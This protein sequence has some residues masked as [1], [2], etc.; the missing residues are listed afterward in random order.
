MRGSPHALHALLAGEEG[1]AVGSRAE[2]VCSCDDRCLL[3]RWGVAFA[4]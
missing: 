1:E 3:P 4:P 2:A